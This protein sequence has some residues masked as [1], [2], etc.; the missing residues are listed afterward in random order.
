MKTFKLLVAEHAKRITELM[1]WDL[2][3]KLNQGSPPMLLD[4]REPDEFSA[5]HI[6]GSINVPRGILETA[7]DYDYS[8]TLPK[9]VKAREDEIVVVCRSG[10]R[11][12]MA[13]CTMQEMG[14]KNVASL[15][16]GLKGWND[17]DQKLVNKNLD[18]IDAE[19]AEEF[20]T[21]EIRPDQMFTK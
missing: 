7:C 16:T 5:M 10:N 18:K 12:V 21:P 9:L 17:Y 3:E 6:Q 13:A 11:S 8:E 14:Y 1:P 15:K 19:Y 2:E 4:I 20:L